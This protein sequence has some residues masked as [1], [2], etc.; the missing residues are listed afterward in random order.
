LMTWKQEVCWSLEDMEGGKGK[1]ELLWGSTDLRTRAL[2]RRKYFCVNSAIYFGVFSGLVAWE[3]MDLLAVIVARETMGEWGK[4]DRWKP[5]WLLRCTEKGCGI[6]LS[7]D[8][9]IMAV[10]KRK[11]LEKR[12]FRKVFYVFCGLKFYAL[13]DHHPRPPQFQLHA[14]QRFSH[15]FPRDLSPTKNT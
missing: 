15:Y 6:E 11:V 10:L 3:T 7:Y 1:M 12:R 9:E 5:Q 4:R 13:G 14:Q 2:L 8:Q